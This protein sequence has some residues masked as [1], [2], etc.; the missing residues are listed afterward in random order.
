MTRPPLFLS[1]ERVLE[2]VAAAK[3]SKN[4]DDWETEIIEMLHEQHP[5]IADSK[6]EIKLKKTDAE[7]GTAIGQIL[8]DDI[9]AIPLII[10]NF[11]LL[12]MDVFYC[13][14]EL[15][16]LKRSTL[17]AKI[18]KPE[19]GKPIKPESGAMS[20]MSIQGA[21]Q[22]PAEGKYAYA[23][24]LM[25]TERD[26][27]AALNNGLTDAGIAY[28]MLTNHVFHDVVHEM[29]K[30]TGKTDV[31]FSSSAPVVK[32]ASSAEQPSHSRKDTF[33]KAASTGV[34]EAVTSLG[35]TTGFLFKEL[36][37]VAADDLTPRTGTSLFVSLDK[38]AHALTSEPIGVREP[39]GPVSLPESPVSGTGVFWTIKE[40]SAV[41]TEPVTI[42]WSSD[43]RF[44][45]QT[46]MGYQLTAEIN[47]KFSGIEKIGSTLYMSPSWVFTK[48]G[49][50]TNISPAKAAN[51]FDWLST[52]VRP[53]QIKEASVTMIAP[54]IQKDALAAFVKV[55]A[56]LDAETGAHIK[57]SEAQTKETVDTL[58]NLNFLNTQN[59]SRFVEHIDKLAE[60][61]QAVAELLL[62]TKLGLDLDSMPLRTAL[63]ALDQVE[64]DLKELRN[65]TA[66]K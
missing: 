64:Q 35:Y 60:A 18:Q 59:V 43:N 34:Y 39:T 55:A 11:K 22:A 2:K 25:F 42:L 9:A 29:V 32:E 54:V 16:A 13:D 63:F 53:E 28:E 38:T 6:V 56:M 14:K 52:Q 48:I 58:L 8:V 44:G 26:I 30:N 21:S 31:D 61:K 12:P 19:L 41:A 62:A 7:T 47:D 1:K 46:A 17:E 15:H 66:Q 5:Y 24:D 23:S 49:T 3:L 4:P 51:D 36:I 40:G 65:A 50:K 57:L 27:C 33:V 37:P 45:L 10:Q 20:D